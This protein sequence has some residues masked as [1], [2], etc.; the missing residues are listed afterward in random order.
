MNK[1]PAPKGPPKLAARDLEGTLDSAR[2]RLG[3]W[4]DETIGEARQKGMF[5][6]LPGHGQPLALPDTDPFAGPEADMY[7]Y[8]KE[9][10]FTPEWIP[11]RKRIASEITW[12]REH[13]Q[14]PERESRL[15][16]L[17][18]LIDQHNR[19]VPNPALNFPKV[20]RQFGRT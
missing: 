4:L 14:H 5:E 9:A 12:L 7:K 1:Q 2:G 13:P 19:L 16:E 8:L 3:H 10:G 18:L 20:S 15:V 6:G 11:M 17:N